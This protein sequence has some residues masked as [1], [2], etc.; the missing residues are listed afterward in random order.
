[1]SNNHFKQTKKNLWSWN[2]MLVC[3]WTACS[4]CSVALEISSKHVGFLSI[5]IVRVNRPLTD[6]RSSNSS[7][8]QYHAD[9]ATPQQKVSANGPS[10]APQPSW[11]TEN[12][13]TRW[14]GHVDEL[15]S[16]YI[17]S[18]RVNR[19][20]D[21]LNVC[22]IF[23]FSHTRKFIC[24]VG[25]EAIKGQEISGSK[26]QRPHSTNEP[27]TNV[28]V[29]ATTSFRSICSERKIAKCIGEKKDMFK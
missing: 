29:N 11:P 18:H 4:C 16:W 2:G 6:S 25:G 27:R 20:K 12:D 8:I 21:A 10:F 23:F 13:L 7:D 26:Q 1:M 17:N 3:I 24:V 9:F 28:Y 14:D 15:E 5:L 22:C 19:T